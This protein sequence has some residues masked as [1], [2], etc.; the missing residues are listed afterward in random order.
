[1]A[2]R[3]ELRHII[4]LS[5]AQPTF[6]TINKVYPLYAVGRVQPFV[7]HISGEGGGGVNRYIDDERNFWKPQFAPKIVS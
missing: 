7:W 1:M 6:Q 2:N 3:T 5:A 4:H